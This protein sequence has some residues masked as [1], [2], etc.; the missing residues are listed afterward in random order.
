VRLVRV[1]QDREGD[2][3]A[4]FEV[5][6]DQGVEVRPDCMRATQSHLLHFTLVNRDAGKPSLVSG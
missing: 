5:R 6:A 2:A 4:V 3:V 1:A